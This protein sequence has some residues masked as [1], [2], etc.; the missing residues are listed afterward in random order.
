MYTINV[1]CMYVSVHICIYAY[2]KT[3]CVYRDRHLCV[4][5]CVCR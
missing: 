1:L 2:I 3:L 5:V 4:C